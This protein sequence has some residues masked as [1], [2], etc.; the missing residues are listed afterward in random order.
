MADYQEHYHLMS[1]GVYVFEPAILEFIHRA[2]AQVNASGTKGQPLAGAPNQPAPGYLDFPDLVKYLLRCHQP[3]HF[4]PF[5]G[6]WL[7]IG[8]NEDYA[9]ASEEFESLFIS[10]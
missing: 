6:Y 2:Q 10:Q 7:D 3:V 8:R 5:T 4:Y 1:M 9:K